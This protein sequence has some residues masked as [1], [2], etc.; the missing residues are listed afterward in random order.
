MDIRH[1]YAMHL[2]LSERAVHAA[3][4]P[5]VARRLVR[6]QDS[7]QLTM[8]R[9]L[10]EHDIVNI[11]M[12]REN[13]LIAMLNKGVLALNVPV[14]GLRRHVL[15]TKTMEWNLYWSVLDPLFDNKFRV[16]SQFLDDPQGLVKRLK[17]VALMNAVLSP[18]LLLF[19]VMY[20]FMKNA[21][22]LYH[23]PS[24]LGELSIPYA[25]ISTIHFIFI[26]LIA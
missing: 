18:F 13:Y 15:L 8:D 6:C 10:L 25:Y 23:H 7:I 11:I 17:A 16:K 3:T 14:P 19:L 12:R 2:G 9:T 26:T 20:F 21:E 24:T 4:W 22:A 1:F 5:E